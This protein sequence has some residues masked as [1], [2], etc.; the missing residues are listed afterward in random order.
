MSD[1]PI[2]NTIHMLALEVVR[3][4]REY[5]AAKRDYA[6]AMSRVKSARSYR[7]GGPAKLDLETAVANGNWLQGEMA[8]YGSAL[9]GLC[10]SQMGE[11]R[12]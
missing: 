10:L 7:T 9:A 2:E 12:A 8:A 3:S 1:N 5:Q 6:D 11:P 4:V